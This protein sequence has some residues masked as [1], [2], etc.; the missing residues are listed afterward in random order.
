MN[1]LLPHVVLRTASTDASDSAI[2]LR[3]GGYAVKKVAD[4]DL[5]VRL[6]AGGHVEA[7][8]IDLPALNAISLV[9]RL[10]FEA[11]GVPLLI[12]YATPQAITRIVGD[13][14]IIARAAVEEDIVRTMDRLLADSELQ[15]ARAI[16]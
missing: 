14:P 16:S 2:A 9:K 3:T 4:D 15:R 1:N 6:A 8:V 7:V 11:P 13:T 5:V 12:V 10:R